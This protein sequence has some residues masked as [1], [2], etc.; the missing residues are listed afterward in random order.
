M[1]KQVVPFS[2]VICPEIIP[3]AREDN[4][5]KVPAGK[6]S[7]EKAVSHDDALLRPFAEYRRNQQG[8]LFRAT[9][10]GLTTS[11]NIFAHALSGIA[12]GQ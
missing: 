12:C 11:L 2:V 5:T 1:R 6:G 10:D 8:G 3:A 9:L 4:S 7:A